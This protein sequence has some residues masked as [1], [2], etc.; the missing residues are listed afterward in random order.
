MSSATSCQLYFYPPYYSGFHFLLKT[1]PLNHCSTLFGN[2]QVN[3]TNSHNPSVQRRRNSEVFQMSRALCITRLPRPPCPIMGPLFQMNKLRALCCSTC[4]PPPPPPVHAFRRF[5]A[6][7]FKS[8][9][10]LPVCSSPVCVT[11]SVTLLTLAAASC[12]P[13]H[14]LISIHCSPKTYHVAMA[15]AF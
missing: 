2:P 9:C 7:G 14:H 4:P 6:N 8:F 10:Y 5:S 1:R 11:H 3:R 15:H 13:E 12:T